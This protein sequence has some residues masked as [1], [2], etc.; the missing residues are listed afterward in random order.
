MIVNEAHIVL[1]MIAF[2]IHCF[3]L[4]IYKTH[5]YKF[6]LSI[7]SGALGL[8]VLDTLRVL[9][10]PITRYRVIFQFRILYSFFGNR[11]NFV[12]YQDDDE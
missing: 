12:N 6:E 2:M 10:K 8:I 11:A 4:D 5:N 1:L 9:L 7:L 3:V